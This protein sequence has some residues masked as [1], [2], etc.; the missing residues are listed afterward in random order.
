M[1]N[2]KKKT[3]EKKNM[4]VYTTLR[5]IKGSLSRYLA[6][7]AIIALGVAFF[8]GLKVTKTAMIETLDQYMKKYEFFDV[9]LL[10]TIG[11]NEGDLE[12]LRRIKEVRQVEGAISIDAF[13]ANKEGSELPFRIHTLT[14]NINQLQVREGRLPESEEECV[15]D[16]S[17]KGYEIG[18]T[19]TISD[20]NTKDTLEMFKNKTYTIVGKVQS[21]LYINF[22][23]GNTTLPGGNI[24]GFFYVT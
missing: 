7:L 2:N 13:G 19:I 23:R 9:R 11:F 3:A 20:S 5:E 6:I 15:L 21:P 18:D 22:E 4:L 10:S 17:M 12:E 14:K 8:T 16:A 24:N 1:K